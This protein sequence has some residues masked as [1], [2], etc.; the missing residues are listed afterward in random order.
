MNTIVHLP[1]G[2][3]RTRAWFVLDFSSPLPASLAARIIQARGKAVLRQDAEML[4][5]QTVTARRFG[6]ERHTSTDLD[7]LGRGIWRLLRQAERAETDGGAADLA[8]GRR[9][10][11]RDH[12]HHPHLIYPAPTRAL[13]E[14]DR[15]VQ[16]RA[17]GHGRLVHD[18]A[19]RVVRCCVGQRTRPG[20]H[21]PRKAMAPGTCCST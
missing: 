3:F 1:M 21:V 13:V 8:P 9:R 16:R 7:L 6:G 2:P 11:D 12:G 5:A 19:V 10:P 4:A 20:G 18:H 15:G 17:D 14:R